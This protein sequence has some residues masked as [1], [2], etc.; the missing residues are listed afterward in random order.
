MNFYS[1]QLLMIVLI[2]RQTKPSDVSTYISST[3][4]CSSYNL[5]HLI[6]FSALFPTTTESN[7]LFSE[8]VTVIW[9]Q[10]KYTSLKLFLK[11]MWIFLS[12]KFCEYFECFCLRST[13]WRIFLY[14]HIDRKFSSKHVTPAVPFMFENWN[15][16][17]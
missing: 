6:R 11:K 14:F 17:S 8:I 9:Y 2:M 7:W 10:V 16:N 4:L 3:V 15:N 5:K 12:F 13:E 1:I